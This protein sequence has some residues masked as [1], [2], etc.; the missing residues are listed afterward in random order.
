MS[1]WKEKIFSSLALAAIFTG[2]SII[3]SM[4]MT[5]RAQ[6]PAMI[7]EGEAHDPMIEEA[8]DRAEQ[9]FGAITHADGLAG[10]PAVPEPP[11]SSDAPSLPAL[12]DTSEDVVQIEAI[13][14]D[15][16]PSM[17]AQ[18]LQKTDRLESAVEIPQEVSEEPLETKIVPLFHAE[19]AG[20][21]E[22]LNGIKSVRGKVEYDENSRALILT[23]IADRIK[24][25]E[26]F[27]KEADIPLETVIFELEEAYDEKT[28]QKIKE[29]LTADIGQ[30]HAD[31]EAGSIVVTDTPEKIAEINAI[32]AALYPL[33][34]EVLLETKVFQI[35][36]NDEYLDG[37]DWEAIVSDYRELAF[38]GFDGLS[39]GK[40]SIGTLSQ[41]DFDILLEALDTVGAV[42]MVSEKNIVADSGKEQIIDIFLSD[43]SDPEKARPA[44]EIPLD[45]EDLQ[46]DAG[47]LEERKIQF[48][49]TPSIKKDKL[50]SVSLEPRVFEGLSTG[51][52]TSARGA[53]EAPD[54]S[55]VVIGS[56]FKDIAVSSAWKIP[57]LGDLPFL[58]FVFRNEGENLRKTEV[59]TFL[60]VSTVEKKGNSEE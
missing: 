20:L 17:S 42:R 21:I 53:V 55:I 49:V 22:V 9:D 5:V 52:K 7:E 46:R 2:I 31:Q 12:P 15:G 29:T 11:E 36:L 43:L 23:D 48:R 40:L 44:S 10:A 35:I 18:M 38:A 34:K 41:E 54:G 51:G 28:L 56:L 3:Y 45:Q 47:S 59:V 19:A 24:G 32:M 57:V 6:E 37:V 26:I 39:S 33:K 30:V 4:H 16:E 25:M 1:N 8:L 14:L 50:L 60:A 27:I 58:G 13:E